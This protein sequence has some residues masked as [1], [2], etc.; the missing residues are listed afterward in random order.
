MCDITVQLNLQHV[1][2]PHIL[3]SVGRKHIRDFT[4]CCKY[5]AG[6]HAAHTADQSAERLKVTQ[7]RSN[8]MTDI[9]TGMHYTSKVVQ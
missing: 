5:V 3:L 8:K 9:V 1:A 4:T 7:R 6:K 2:H